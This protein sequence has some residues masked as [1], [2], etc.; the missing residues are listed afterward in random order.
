[1]DRN[2]FFESMI[3]SIIELLYDKK[4]VFSVGKTYCEFQYIVVSYGSVN[5]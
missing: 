4:D 3:T 5:G 2:S 1:M